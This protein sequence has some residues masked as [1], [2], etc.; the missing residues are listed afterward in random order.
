V[1]GDIMGNTTKQSQFFLILAILY[2]NSAYSQNKISFKDYFFPQTK[3]EY[4]MK[5]SNKND[6]T[7]LLYKTIKVLGQDTIEVLDYEKNKEFYRSLT[8]VVR[9]DEITVIECKK[10][11]NSKV[12]TSDIKLAIWAHS[13]SI[14]SNKVHFDI[15]TRDTCTTPSLDCYWEWFRQ[16][17]SK[18][19]E[20]TI[21]WNG[22]LFKTIT[23][24]FDEFVLSQPILFSSISGMKTRTI[25]YTFAKNVGLIKI[26]STSK[27]PSYKS[28]LFLQN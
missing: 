20:G 21:T 27:K 7:T 23:I 13:K 3:E 2:L 8:F 18:L 11:I 17:Q 22:K 5:F 9:E 24:T 10:G 25:S 26:I 15:Q 1:L 16:R 19:K 28:S 6:S 4:T 12:F 14:N